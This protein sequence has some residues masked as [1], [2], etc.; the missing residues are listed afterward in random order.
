[1]DSH[2]PDSPVQVHPAVCRYLLDGEALSPD[3]AQNKGILETTEQHVIRGD[4]L[5]V[6]ARLPAESVDLVHTS[7]PYNINKPYESGLSD[8]ASSS[9]Y[10]EFLCAAIGEIKRVVRPGGSIFWQ[11]GYTQSRENDSEIIPID[12]LSYEIFRSA[13]NPFLLWDRIIWRYWG[14]HAFTKK[15]TNKHETVLWFVKPGEEPTFLV[16]AV[17]EKSKE[18]DKRNNLWGRNPGNVWEVDRVA[19]GSTEQTSHIAVFPE[20]I[21]ERIVRACSKPSDLVLDPFSGSGT[22]AK[23]AHGLG[24]RWIGIE[25][26]PIYADESCVRVG[27][28]QPSEQESLASE[29]IKR[30]AFKDKPGKLKLSEVFNRVSFWAKGVSI[31]ELQSELNLDIDRVFSDGSGRNQA[32]REVWMKYDKIMDQPSRGAAIA[33]ADELLSICYKLRQQFNGVTR[34]KS[35]LTALATC[36]DNFAEYS[37]A[38]PYIAKIARQEPSSFELHDAD[39]T[40]LS[41]SRRV[42]SGT[43]DLQADDVQD[44]GGIEETGSQGRLPL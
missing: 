42:S 39:L 5:D 33:L 36:L 10:Q 15:F 23:V 44:E 19:Y 38:I 20:E 35:A 17:R 1:M 2:K 4:A 37:F 40:F 9:E 26:S 13:P 6:L 31:D 24:R 14:G 18:Y 16:D 29:L 43:F 34:F 12:L 32:K 21:T 28:Q 7:P 8:R 22:V 3:N 30:L 41:P 27:Y 11:T 25:I